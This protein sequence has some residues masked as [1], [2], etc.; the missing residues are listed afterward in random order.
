MSVVEEY[1]DRLFRRLLDGLADLEPVRVHGAP[2]RRTPTV[3]FTVEG[4]PNQ[5]VYE[6]LAARGVNAPASNFYAYEASRWIGLG[7]DGGVR[8]GLA[9]YTTDADIDRLLGALAEVC[10]RRA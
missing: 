1:E 2:A 5:D 9:P 10:D 4:V 6:G 7:E 3:L 8:A